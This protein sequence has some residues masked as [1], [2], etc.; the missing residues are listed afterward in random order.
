MWAI[1]GLLTIFKTE[2][3]VNPWIIVDFQADYFVHKI[4][5]TVKN[6]KRFKPVTVSTFDHNQLPLEKKTC[7]VCIS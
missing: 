5:V 4:R 6:W 2:Y 7:N 3:S 1:D